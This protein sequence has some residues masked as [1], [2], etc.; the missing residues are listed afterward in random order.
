LAIGAAPA[1]GAMTAFWRTHNGCSVYGLV[2]TIKNHSGSDEWIQ[3]QA[4][5]VN[6]CALYVRARNTY[7]VSGQGW[8]A[9]PYKEHPATA[10]RTDLEDVIA[11]RG[12]I[13]FF[14]GSLS[15]WYVSDTL[16]P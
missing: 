13:Q 3:T 15:T 11:V 8:F 16:I 12:H 5:D 2:Q 6:T 9:T 1:H 4:T 14:A 10:Q 7:Y